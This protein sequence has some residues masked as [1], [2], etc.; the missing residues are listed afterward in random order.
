MR[1][2]NTA[3]M[4]PIYFAR[5]EG[6][7]WSSKDRSSTVIRLQKGPTAHLQK[8]Y[9][10]DPRPSLRDIVISIRRLVARD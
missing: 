4:Y 10:S 9:P 8:Q 2:T 3:Y 5:M 7:H 1:A 6:S